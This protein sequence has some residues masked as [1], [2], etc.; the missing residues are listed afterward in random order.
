MQ[1][2]RLSRTSD[3]SDHSNGYRMS[4]LAPTFLKGKGSQQSVRHASPSFVQA[5]QRGND[6]VSATL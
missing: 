6:D 3:R 5:A 1:T 2:S 4:F